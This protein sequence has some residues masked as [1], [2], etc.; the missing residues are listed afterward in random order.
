MITDETPLTFRYILS[1]L[2]TSFMFCFILLPS[3]YKVIKAGS[4]VI[5]FKEGKYTCTS[6]FS[7]DEIFWD[8]EGDTPNRKLFKNKGSFGGVTTFRNNKQEIGLDWVVKNNPAS[9]VKALNKAYCFNGIVYMDVNKA[10]EKLLKS[11]IEEI[12]EKLYK[13]KTYVFYSL[14]ESDLYPGKN[15]VEL[16]LEFSKPFKKVMQDSGIIITNVYIE[17]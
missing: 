2:V 15:T 17:I 5:E 11:K 4:M 6:Y 1:P 9:M 7:K 3:D 8:Y 13:K 12:Q 16:V 10:V 14:I